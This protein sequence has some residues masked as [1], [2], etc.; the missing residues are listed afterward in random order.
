MSTARRSASPPSS[1]GARRRLGFSEARRRRMSALHA[2]CAFCSG[3]SRPRGVRRREVEP[4]LE[5]L[6]V[7]FIRARGRPSRARV[8]HRHLLFLP[9]DSGRA[10]TRRRALRLER[11]E[12]LQK[13]PWQSAASP[14]RD[15]H[16]ARLPA[17][18]GGARGAAAASQC[19]SADAQRARRLA[20]RS[21]RRAAGCC[22]ICDLRCG[23]LAARP[24][25][26]IV[27][28]RP[29]TRPPRPR[30]RR[31]RRRVGAVSAGANCA[32]GDRSTGAARPPR[33]PG[34]F[35]ARGVDGANSATAQACPP[36][37]RPPFGA[38]ARARAAVKKTT[39]QN[40]R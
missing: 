40:S 16:R 17:V 25:W 20:R 38:R 35:G 32:R 2:T 8:H 27:H 37:S 34:R 39:G 12:P 13:S 28:F 7:H 36:P 10:A 23:A 11:R 22:E 26:R 6:L 4:P 33:P 3:G 30:G 15:S 29:S 19:S 18:V 1:E 5:R 9:V 14:C 24:S 31:R 21:R